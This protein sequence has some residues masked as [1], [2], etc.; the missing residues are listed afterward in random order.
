MPV[1]QNE[2]EVH[3]RL[4]VLQGRL[5]ATHR[6][7]P[8]AEKGQILAEQGTHIVVVLHH[9]HT[10]ACVD[11][12]GRH[13]QGL[14]GGNTH[15]DA[16]AETGARAHLALDPDFPSHALHQ[17][18]ADRK[19]QAG[20]A[21]FSRDGTVRLAEGGEQPGLLLRSQSRAGIAHQKAQ[22]D[23]VVL[24]GIGLHGQQ[25]LA[26]LGEFERILQQID[27]DLSQ[28]QGVA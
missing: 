19:T 16:E 9:Q 11:R 22:G 10:F 3:P 18:F 12:R 24:G 15:S 26:A 28:A 4:D 8:A 17:L 20:A 27:E 2:I 1:Q 6:L 23:H 25:D 21:M 5:A 14:G 7:M 13:G